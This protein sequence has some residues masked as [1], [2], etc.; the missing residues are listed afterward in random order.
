MGTTTEA[1]FNSLQFEKKLTSLKDSQDSINACCQWCL[2]N[3]DHHKKI[4][5]VWLNVLK[6]VKVEQRL[7]LFY[8]ANDVIQYSK[9]K[10]YEYVESWGTALQ[11]AT[12]LVRDDKVKHKILRIF[13]I[14]E[15]RGV[16]NE[17]FISDLCGLIKAVPSGAKGDEPHEFQA[18]Y[19]INKIKAS[20]NFERDADKKLTVLTEHNPK[21]QITPDLCSSLKDR[22]HVDDVEKEIDVYAKHMED[23]INALKL[24]IKNRIALI[25]VLKQAETQLEADR[26]DVKIVA[27][28]YKMFGQ[29]VKTFQKKLEE[30]KSTL[31]SP[32]PSPDVNAP[33]PSP[34][35]DL[36]L[37][38]GDSCTLTQKSN[39]N[40]NSYTSNQTTYSNTNFYDPQPPLPSATESNT[41]ITNGFSSF[42]G[43]NLP[44]N[45]QNLNNTNL[46]QSDA[47]PLPVAAPQ[48]LPPPSTSNY[49]Y[50]SLLPPPV[51]PFESQNYGSTET[52]S[53]DQFSSSY[54]QQP[55]DPSVTT[56]STSSYTD[57]TS[58]DPS[59]AY[60]G[61]A[62]ASDDYNPEQ[63]V[64]TWTEADLSWQT[65]GPDL[66]TPESPPQ[67]EK[68]SF[69]NPVEYHDN[70]R[71]G[72][73]DVDH[74][75]LPEI[76]PELNEDSFSSLG[77]NGKD[78]DHRN[79]IRLT[80]S[81]SDNNAEITTANT[82]ILDK[83][84]RNKD[85]DYRIPI[86]IENLKLPPPPPPPATAAVATPVVTTPGKVN[87]K[88]TGGQ[89]QD[90]VENID[91]DLSD[92]EAV[93]KA[94]LLKGSPIKMKESLQPPPPLPDLPDEIIDPNTGAVAF[95]NCDFNNMSNPPP[96]WGEPLPPP[97]P[98]GNYP[99]TLLGNPMEPPPNWSEQNWSG[100]GPE[101]GD[102]D[103][104]NREMWSNPNFRGRNG[105]Q[106]PRNFMRRDSNNGSNGGQGRGGNGGNFRGGSFR[107]RD[108]RAK[109]QRGS[110]AKR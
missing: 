74:R 86:N 98:M 82:G 97:P 45:L 61:A 39:S 50:P 34:D 16:Y 38:D 107:G 2:Q 31:I 64:E 84:Y 19:V 85:Q 1:E 67:F 108:N 25:S 104:R 23:Y 81:P 18:H 33:S 109:K 53:A 44:F 71:S 10:H 30:H 59:A 3:R 36:D 99:P 42:I 52:T 106:P 49:P 13:K 15:Q 73:L 54:P 9:R 7:I 75:I 77:G 78:V 24:E 48:Q 37:P 70:V 79:L 83:D 57:T 41:F 100:P 68:E 46:F 90:N 20:V 103:W 29:R 43:S 94:A 88:P 66:E 72:A 87:E 91:M 6:R 14:W 102:N 63:D 4:V 5:N 26:K 17:E 69:S 80:G 12:T 93:G 8:L 110:S 62:N 47:P 105:H 89:F 60:A 76:A 22:A 28:A 35:S 65:G 40:S 92:D 51:P 32:V 96:G 11:K 21:I 55:Y 101:E 56:Y 95:P 27:N 58:Y